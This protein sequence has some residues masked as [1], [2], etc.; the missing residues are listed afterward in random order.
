MANE[1]EEILG[2]GTPLG[3]ILIAVVAEVLSGI[4]AAGD[5]QALM[6]ALLLTFKLLAIC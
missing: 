3:A 5:V 6:A 2:G 1:R 4:G